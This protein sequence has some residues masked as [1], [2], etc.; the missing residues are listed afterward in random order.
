MTRMKSTVSAAEA[1][2]HFSECLRVVEQGNAV[3]ITRHGRAVAALVPAQEAALLKRLR[4]A[5]PQAGL[6]GVAGGWKGSEELVERLVH[7]RS[8]AVRKAPRLGSR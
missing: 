6:A 3:L 8:A 4:A 5:G 7:L 1:K 2:A